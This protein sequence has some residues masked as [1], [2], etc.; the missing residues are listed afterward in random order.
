M[1]ADRYAWMDGALCAQA[2]PDLW[3]SA[4]GGGTRTPKRICGDCP[5]TRECDAHAAALHVFDGLA[6]NG[7]WGG[8][9]KRQRDN[10]RR[11]LGEA[12]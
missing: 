10:D 5:V 7:V 6:M 2:D 11:E 4:I 8:R 3:T 9:S 1:S 12:A